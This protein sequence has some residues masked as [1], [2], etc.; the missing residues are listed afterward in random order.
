MKKKW[1]LVLCLLLALILVAGGVT[2][3]LVNRTPP[4]TDPEAPFVDLSDRE[5]ERVL[6]A[7]GEYWARS[8]EKG[9]HKLVWYE[10]RESKPLESFE[11]E[12]ERY[13]YLYPK[14]Y[15]VKYYGTFNGYHIVISA[16]GFEINWKYTITIAGCR[17]SYACPS[18][19]LLACKDGVATPLAEVYERGH[20]S[21]EQIKLIY[22]CYG[23]YN[24]QV[25]LTS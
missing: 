5:K 1:K 24:Y 25:Y 2:L 23:R 11:N 4:D 17:F 15:G 6:K 7:V 21:D 3:W 16:V 20:L 9:P 13:E 14:H 22:Q 8:P 18:F 19:E 10:Y 12:T